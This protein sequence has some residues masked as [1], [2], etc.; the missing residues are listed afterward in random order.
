MVYALLLGA[1][2]IGLSKIGWESLTNLKDNEKKNNQSTE[3]QR[4]FE[5]VKRY[6][7]L[8]RICDYHVKEFVNENPKA[9]TEKAFAKLVT[10]NNLGLTGRT[11]TQL[12][13]DSSNK[14]VTKRYQAR[15]L[16]I[17][18][19]RPAINPKALGNGIFKAYI[20]PTKAKISLELKYGKCANNGCDLAQLQKQVLKFEIPVI[21]RTTLN[22]TKIQSIACDVPFSDVQKE[23]LEKSCMGVGGRID[24]ADQICKFPLFD[25]CKQLREG[26]NPDI[27][28]F[29]TCMIQHVNKE[30]SPTEYVP[31]QDSICRL[32]LITAENSAKAVNYSPAILAKNPNTGQTEIKDGSNTGNTWRVTTKYC[33]KLKAWQK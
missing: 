28:K 4:D 12:S 22:G 10:V 8:R 9:E 13:F 29:K 6:L 15:V 31:F 11:I 26:P 3:V 16:D 25:P 21:I 33:S 1:V 20:F 19:K 24:Q 2:V 7:S 14:L 30:I 32:D 17:L 5:N 18:F 23:A 27:E